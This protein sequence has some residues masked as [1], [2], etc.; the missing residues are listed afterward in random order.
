[1]AENGALLLLLLCSLSVEVSLGHARYIGCDLAIKSGKTNGG[2][3]VMSVTSLMGA[4]PQTATIVNPAASTF[5]DG[6]TINLNFV[7]MSS[8]IVHA[9]AGTF[10]GDM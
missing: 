1:M 5:E 7:Q 9:T 10:G 3:S 8:G 4:S 2:T 6:D